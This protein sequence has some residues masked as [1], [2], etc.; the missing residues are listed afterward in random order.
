V[1]QRRGNGF[2]WTAWTSR[3]WRKCTHGAAPEAGQ[4]IQPSTVVGVERRGI[5][6]QMT[7]M[8]RR[9]SRTRTARGCEQTSLA[10]REQPTGIVR[11]ARS[12]FTR[13]RRGVVYANLARP[14]TTLTKNIATSNTTPAMASGISNHVWSLAE[15]VALLPAWAARAER[16]DEVKPPSGAKRPISRHPSSGSVSLRDRSG[17][18]AGS[19]Q[20]GPARSG[21]NRQTTRGMDP[22]RDLPR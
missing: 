13:C 6:K 17:K 8:S 15:L 4:A 22:H 19:S 11:S 5:R 21:G 12:K 14:R 16:R 10:L 3:C 7:R 1:L 18:D 9:A 20:R 2:G